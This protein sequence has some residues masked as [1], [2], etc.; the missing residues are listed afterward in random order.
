MHDSHAHNSAAV[1]LQI[2]D[3][4]TGKS[5]DGYAAAATRMQQPQSFLSPPSGHHGLWPVDSPNGNMPNRDQ[6]LQPYSS[7]ESAQFCQARS[8]VGSCGMNLQHG[9][10]SGLN[11]GES[12]PPRPAAL[13]R[14]TCLATPVSQRPPDEFHLCAHSQLKDPAL[15]A[16]SGQGAGRHGVLRAAVRSDRQQKMTNVV[17]NAFEAR[18]GSLHADAGARGSGAAAHLQLNVQAAAGDFVSLQ[19]HSAAMNVQ[20]HSAA[21]NDGVQVQHDGCVGELSLRAM[22][23]GLGAVADPF[24]AVVGGAGPAE[25]VDTKMEDLDNVAVHEADDEEEEDGPKEVCWRV[26]GTRSGA[27]PE[28]A[29]SSHDAEQCASA[30]VCGLQQLPPQSIHCGQAREAAAEGNGGHDNAARQ[31]EAEVPVAQQTSLRHDQPHDRASDV[32]AYGN[33][34]CHA[35]RSASLRS[36]AAVS[37]TGAAKPAPVARVPRTAVDVVGADNGAADGVKGKRKAGGVWKSRKANILV[38]HDMLW[39]RCSCVFHRL[40]ISMFRRYCLLDFASAVLL[41][42]STPGAMPVSSL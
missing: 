10:N 11:A 16:A 40:K 36:G 24:E 27:K 29:V 25:A 3:P 26:L 12:T 41:R 39:L 6:G 38:R 15:G 22:H 31:E 35:G 5:A 18:C 28:Q 8:P 23:S 7:P 14:E 13:L 4:N 32:P 42:S 37:G 20:H 21:M 33:V 34:R 30:E 1:P 2:S 19:H 9:Q 17:E